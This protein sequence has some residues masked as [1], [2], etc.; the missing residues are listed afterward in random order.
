MRMNRE[1]PKNP[2]IRV[3]KHCANYNTGH[4][5]SGIIIDSKL[6][7]WVDVDLCGK[8]CLITDNKECNYFNKIV[9]PA[10]KEI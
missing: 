8:K 6:R 5:C 2:N 9:A 4:I 1:N 3:K 10:I 7:Q